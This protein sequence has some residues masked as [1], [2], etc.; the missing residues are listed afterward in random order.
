MAKRLAYADRYKRVLE[1]LMDIPDLAGLVPYPVI[2][3]LENHVRYVWTADEWRKLISV[4]KTGADLIYP[5]DAQNILWS[6]LRGMHQPQTFDEEVGDCYNYPVYA[7]FNSFEPYNPYNDPTFIPPGYLVPPFIIGG[8]IGYEATDLIVR[9]DSFPIFANW[10]DIIFG[11]L[12]TVKITTVGDGQIEL[13]LLNTIQGGYCVLKNNAPPNILDIFLGIFEPDIRI[14]DTQIDIAFPTELDLVISE[15]WDLEVGTGVENVLYC[16]F[17][18]A[19]DDIFPPF[20]LPL[21]FG[22]GI[23]QVGLCGFESAGVIMG[24]TDLRRVGEI[25]ETFEGGVWT[26]KVDL[27]PLHDAHDAAL[28]AQITSNDD[29]IAILQATDVTH[30]SDIISLYAENDAQDI[31]IQANTDANLA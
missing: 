7:P 28:Q 29:D 4:V 18:P 27:E 13:D 16:T 19:V 3:D 9:F 21:R 25:L 11:S 1:S 10:W 17:I 5:E 26:P 31:L 12:P 6:I 15:E 24:I 30:G 23:R 8:G 14:V 2:D 20:G 22:G